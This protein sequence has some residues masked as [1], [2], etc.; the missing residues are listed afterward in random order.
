MGD[1]IEFY[2]EV[3]DKDKKSGAEKSSSSN[4]SDSNNNIDHSKVVEINNNK[5]SPKMNDQSLKNTKLNPA[6]REQQGI[7]KKEK[8]NKTYRNETT[9]K[10]SS[11]HHINNSKFNISTNKNVS[12]M[13][14]S[15]TRMTRSRGRCDLSLSNSVHVVDS[16]ILNKTASSIFEPVIT[17][18]HTE[19]SK[20]QRCLLQKRLMLAVSRCFNFLCV[21]IYFYR[22]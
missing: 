6:N 21:I 16:T 18:S 19:M 4:K 13:E 3:V 11:N 15:R 20:S 2:C 10:S 12:V 22:S 1:D 14:H 5:P 17:R 9:Q 8:S 7:V